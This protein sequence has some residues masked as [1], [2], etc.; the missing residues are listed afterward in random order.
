M[1][2]CSPTFRRRHLKRSSP[3]TMDMARES[4]VR[5]ICRRPCDGPPMLSDAATGFG[6]RDL[7]LMRTSVL[8]VGGGPVGST[9]A[10]D[11]ASRG[12]E[13]VV[14]ERN[15]AGQMPGVKC[16]HVAA[17]TME[18]FRRLGI[19]RIVRDTGLPPDHPNDVAFRTAAV[20]IEF[21][22]IMIPCRRDRYAR[23]D[24]P[25]GWWPTPE[26]PHRINQIYLDPL[27]AD[28]ARAHQRIR[29]ID[30]LEVVGYTQTAAWNNG[31]GCR[32][33]WPATHSL[34]LSCWMRWPVIPYP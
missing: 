7:S 22:R 8:I 19:A 4:N 10:L 23:K 24:G 12:I 15:P 26:P 27:L 9:L 3:R 25:D 5:P 20:G 32:L 33:R 34:R 28:R 31:G 1:A 18:I 14:A 6:Q 16:N 29:Y 30:R 21:A 11:L 13:V 17:R 2:D